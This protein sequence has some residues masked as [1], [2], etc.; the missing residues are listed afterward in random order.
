M[1]DTPPM[2][3]ARRLAS[4]AGDNETQGLTSAQVRRYRHKA[5]H[6]FASRHKPEAKPQRHDLE[7]LVAT[8]DE[9]MR[10]PRRVASSDHLERLDAVQVAQRADAPRKFNITWPRVGTARRGRARGE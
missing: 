9:S 1:S 6:D 8:W 3:Q 2:T 7:G 5:R 10:D 4:Y